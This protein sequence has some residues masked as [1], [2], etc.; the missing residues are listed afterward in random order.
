MT[1]ILTVRSTIPTQ[2][3]GGNKV[4]L[5]ETHAEHP[6]GEAFVAGPNP[7]QV[8]RTPTVQ[9]LL[10]DGTLEIVEGDGDAEARPAR[11]PA[12]SRSRPSIPPIDEDDNEKPP[13]EHEG[14]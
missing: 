14:A 4:A 3:D 12:R 9:K 13:A 7:V 11:P 6:D 8:A 1:E 2:P 5:F 10:G